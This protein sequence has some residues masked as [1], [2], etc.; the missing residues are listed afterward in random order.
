MNKITSRLIEFSN[1]YSLSKNVTKAVTLITSHE[2]VSG[3]QNVTVKENDD[4]EV[5]RYIWK[6]RRV[7]ACELAMVTR[8]A[9]WSAEVGHNTCV[10]LRSS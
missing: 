7:S 6:I 4:R 3:R 8:R 1:I 10:S 5:G 9:V 2:V